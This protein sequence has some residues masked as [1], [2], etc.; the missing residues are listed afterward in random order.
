MVSI[1]GIVQNTTDSV[2]LYEV[3]IF[4]SSCILIQIREKRRRGCRQTGGLWKNIWIASSTIMSYEV[5]YEH[6]KCV[7]RWILKM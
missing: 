4:S 2:F 1:C 5:V 7:G 6:M 3:S